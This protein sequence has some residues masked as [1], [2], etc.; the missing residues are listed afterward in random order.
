M[1]AADTILQNRYRIVRVIGQGGMGAV[2][3]AVDQRLGNTVAL[4]QTLF[5]DQAR[6]RAFERE[7]KLLASLR[8]PALPRVSDYFTEENGQFLVMEYIAGEDLSELRAKQAN[9]IFPLHDVLKWADQ[10]LDAL[11]Y[12]HAHEPPVI[13]RDI[14]PQNLKLTSRGQIIL[15]DFGLAKGSFGHTVSQHGTL[16]TATSIYGFTPNFAPLEQIQGMGTDPRSDLYALA[17]TLYYLATGTRP[18]DA[19]TRATA[20]LNNQP[21]PL[22]PANEVTRLVPPDVASVLHQ[23]MAQNREQRPASA[24]E[25]RRML[26]ATSGANFTVTHNPQATVTPFA[27]EK[28]AAF[29]NEN[30]PTVQIANHP[31]RESANNIPIA[32]VNSSASNSAPPLSESSDPNGARV[33]VPIAAESLRDEEP[34]SVTTRVRANSRSRADGSASDAVAFAPPAAR[35]KNRSRNL[36]IAGG[37]AAALV[38]GISF[39]AMNVN[40]SGNSSNAN[41]PVMNA[42]APVETAKPRTND[43]NTATGKT[44]VSENLKVEPRKVEAGKSNANETASSEKSKTSASNA[45]TSPAQR[46][47]HDEDMDNTGQPSEKRVKRR[48]AESDSNAENNQS[49]E[50]SNEGSASRPRR[51]P[52]DN[53]DFD[54]EGSND[55]DKSRNPNQRQNSN[56]SQQQQDIPPWMRRM[57]RRARQQQQQRSQPVPMPTDNPPR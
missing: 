57:I 3:L 45:K 15:L 35:A 7:A 50:A 18:P 28:T 40:R 33:V 51:V 16:H 42:P 32:A 5:D 26:H 36:W 52:I 34:A 38:A 25:M 56:Q 6:C 21:D 39:A 11:E 24:V 31:A 23:A 19:L 37:I 8:H 46:N 10:L 17:A 12:L 48:N 2:Y 30:A 47:P 20:V 54:N 9:G 14:K 55:S 29:V 4:K 41:A 1:L 49:D 27:D 53:G 43:L 44:S 13:H 22:R